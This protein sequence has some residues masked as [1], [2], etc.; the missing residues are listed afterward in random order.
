M[1]VMPDFSV[2]NE[3]KAPREVYILSFMYT[4]TFEYSAFQPVWH[5]PKSLSHVTVAMVNKRIAVII[6]HEK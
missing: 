2:R 3:N 4:Y 5:R 1:G 6:F